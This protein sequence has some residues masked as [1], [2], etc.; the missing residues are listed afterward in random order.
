MFGWLL[1]VACL[2]ELDRR[3]LYELDRREP[4]SRDATNLLASAEPAPG[5]FEYR[6]SLAPYLHAG[7]Q[8]HT[9]HK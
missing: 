7:N 1:S 6:A 3:C 5:R 2:Y 4:S 9:S 8:T